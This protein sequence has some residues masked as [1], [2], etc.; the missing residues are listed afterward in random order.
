V[1][2]SRVFAGVFAFSTVFLDGKLWWIC[3]DLVALMW[4][5]SACVSNAKN[6]P[7]F[8]TLF[9]GCDSQRLGLEADAR[10]LFV[11]LRLKKLGY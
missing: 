8:S 7:L 11:I 6:M 1:W 9:F 4:W 2:R 3:G 5:L 10:K